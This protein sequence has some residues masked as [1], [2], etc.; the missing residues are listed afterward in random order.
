MTEKRCEN[1]KY[2]IGI[3]CGLTDGHVGFDWWC[4]DFEEKG[5]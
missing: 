4:D 3:V 5:D 2:L 1:C